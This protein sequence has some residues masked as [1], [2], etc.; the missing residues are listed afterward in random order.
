MFIA[1]EGERDSEHKSIENQA[2]LV[3]LFP[4]TNELKLSP[5]YFREKKKEI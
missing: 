5:K 4:L 3:L 2:L 1:A